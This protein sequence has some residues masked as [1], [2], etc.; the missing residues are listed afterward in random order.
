MLLDNSSLF[1]ILKLISQNLKA[2]TD[3]NII[4]NK[5]NVKNLSNL[6]ISLKEKIFTKKETLKGIFKNTKVV[7]QLIKLCPVVLENLEI[8]KTIKIK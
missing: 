7:S 1:F 4:N 6:K 5:N 8:N 2:K 3:K